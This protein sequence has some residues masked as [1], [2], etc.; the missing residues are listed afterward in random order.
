MRLIFLILFILCDGALDKEKR[1]PEYVVIEKDYAGTV[2]LDR[3]T[4]TR[5]LEK[6]EG[7][8]RLED[9][10]NGKSVIG[11]GEDAGEL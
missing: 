10:R 11:A 8:Y 7:I 3:E 5:Y 9:M 2:L 6:D 4:G 1:Q